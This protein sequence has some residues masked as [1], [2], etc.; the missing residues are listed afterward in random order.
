[1]SCERLVQEPACLL[2]TPQAEET[3]CPERQLL[4]RLD[5]GLTAG[6]NLQGLCILGL[7]H[8]HSS[9]VL[10]DVLHE[11][12]AEPAP[13]RRTEMGGRLPVVFQVLVDMTHEAMWPA[14]LG[15]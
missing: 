7:L 13:Q 14:V 5:P 6:Q 1:V 10:P 15:V 4:R 3:F 8:E 2:G 12:F 9:Q 11:S